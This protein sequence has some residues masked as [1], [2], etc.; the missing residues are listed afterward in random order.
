MLGP[1]TV[2]ISF[3][4]ENKA[5]TDLFPGNRCMVWNIAQLPDSWLSQKSGGI[6]GYFLKG[7]VPCATAQ[8]YNNIYWFKVC[9]LLQEK[10]K[11][12]WRNVL[13]QS[14]C[15]ACLSIKSNKRG[16]KVT[17]SKIRIH[18]ATWPV[19]YGVIKLTQKQLFT[20]Y[21]LIHLWQAP[22]TSHPQGT[23]SACQLLFDHL[24][25]NMCQVVC[26]NRVSHITLPITLHIS[27]HE[28]PP[29]NKHP[30]PPDYVLLF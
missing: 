25:R 12:K 29:N 28:M 10:K 4:Q 19:L 2:M 3:S 22:Q 24:I 11:L 30:P 20:H 26:R 15:Q 13:H 16:R 21:K 23:F 9:Y 8:S 27:K 6:T 5:L 18:K 14:L 17:K 7:S 1:C